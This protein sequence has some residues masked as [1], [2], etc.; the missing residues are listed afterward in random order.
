MRKLARTAVNKEK[1][2]LELTSL[3]KKSYLLIF[4]V[5]AACFCNIQDRIDNNFMILLLPSFFA[6]YEVISGG[7][8]LH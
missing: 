8:K 3:G 2:C 7:N 4:S 5:Y 1:Q 6:S